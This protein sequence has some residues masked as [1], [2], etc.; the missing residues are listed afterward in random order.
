[1][2]ILTV[3]AIALLTSFFTILFFFLSYQLYLKK[4]L[5]ETIEEEAKDIRA[6][7]EKSL[8]ETGEEL[9]PEFRDALTEAFTEALNE[10]LPEFR[11]EVSEGFSEAGQELLPEYRTQ[12]QEAFETALLH[13]FSGKLV[14]KTALTMAK[15]GTSIVGTGLD[16]LFGKGTQKKP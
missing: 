5:L 8:M 6:E 3:C 9:V 16:L 14:E 11:K 1:M 7:F 13:V 12:V 10:A 2:S 4:S 15:K